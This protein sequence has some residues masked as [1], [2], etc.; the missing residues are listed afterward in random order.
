MSVLFINACPREGSRTKILADNYLK[1]VKQEVIQIDLEQIGLLPLNG[2][3]LAKRDRLIANGDFSNEFFSLA[4]QF[5]KADEI[6]IASPFW[7]LSFPALVKI[8]FENITVS[9]ITFKYN[10]GNPVGLCNAKK[11]TY[12]TTAGGK[13]LVD[14]GYSYI[15]T[16]ATQFYGI[17]E[18]VC[19]RAENLDVMGIIGEEVLNQP[20]SKIK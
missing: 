10:N 5:A 8:Y 1:D 19:F 12:I 20:I 15:K 2:E 9:G 17:S 6:V 4:R 3:R 14:F 18:T 13:I 11:L 7:D 16:L